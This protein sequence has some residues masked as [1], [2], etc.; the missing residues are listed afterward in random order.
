ML[1]ALTPVMIDPSYMI[2]LLLVAF[3]ASNRF[4]TPRIVRSQTS[5]VQFWLSGGAHVVS[6]IGVFMLLAWAVRHNSSLVGAMRR[7]ARRTSPIWTLRW[8]PR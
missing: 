2:A 3:H 1:T 7:K 6:S 8:S 4:N 5:R